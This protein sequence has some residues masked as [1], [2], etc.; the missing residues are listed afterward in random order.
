MHRFRNR[1]DTCVR[2]CRYGNCL[3]SSQ[4]TGYSCL[5]GKAHLACPP[6]IRSIGGCLPG[7]LV[8]VNGIIIGHATGEEAV[9]TI[10]NC[11]KEL[12]DYSVIWE[13]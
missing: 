13:E 4:K 5:S 8:F 12:P 6:E 3:I 10:R 7:E 2:L 1:S 11:L 9:I